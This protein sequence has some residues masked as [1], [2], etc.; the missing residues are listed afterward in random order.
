LAKPHQPFS[1]QGSA[2]FVS[3]IIDASRRVGTSSP[4][5]L[6]GHIGSLSDPI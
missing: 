1:T 4:A 2:T 6:S 5:A 3:A